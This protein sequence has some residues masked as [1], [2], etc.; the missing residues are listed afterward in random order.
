MR[1]KGIVI[2]MCLFFNA[3]SLEG[4]C[5]VV[6]NKHHRCNRNRITFEL[7]NTHSRTHGGLTV[8]TFHF[9]PGP[10]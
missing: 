3:L 7:V 4:T 1:A 9:G 8:P 6:T 10:G 2:F 5:N